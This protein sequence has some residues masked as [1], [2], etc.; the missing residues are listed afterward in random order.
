MTF[1]MQ[2]V[3]A[4]LA[5]VWFTDGDRA[6]VPRQAAGL[7][8][9][10]QVERES[11]AEAGRKSCTV[12]S[13]GRNVTARLFE[14]PVTQ[15]PAWSVLVGFDGQPGSVRY[16]RINRK[17]YQTDKPGFLGDAAAQIVARLKAPGEVV[18]EWAKRPGDAKRGGLFATGDFAAKAADCEDWMSGTGI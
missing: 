17:I 11:G 16:L 13:L 6:A 14:D 18:Y 7:P 2:V 1:P 9:T 5:V 4:T 10:W 12:V 3:L 8:M 15:R